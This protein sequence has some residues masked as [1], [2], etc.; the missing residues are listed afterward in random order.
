MSTLR[1]QRFV[2][3]EIHPYLDDVARLRIAVFRDYPYLYDGTREYETLYLER[4]SRSSHSF[5]V[6]AFD[7]EIIVGAT[8]ALPLLEEMAEVQAPFKQRRWDV[9]RVLYL[10]ESVLQP[11]YRGQG[12]GVKFFQ[13]R[14]RYAR[15]FHR[16]THTAFCAVV[17]S[18]FDPRRPAGYVPLDRFW[19]HRGYVRHAELATTFTWKEIEEAQES[20]KRMMFWLKELDEHRTITDD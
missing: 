8:T 16:V 13:E 5:F 1:L 11:R 12:I 2:G 6:V 19:Q 3:A 7:G 10:G 20:P 4:Y 14:E 17:R 18:D 15:T 9:D